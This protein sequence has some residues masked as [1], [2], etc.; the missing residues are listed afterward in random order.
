MEVEF[1]VRTMQCNLR[2]AG[3]HLLLQST[4][5]VIVALHY[6]NRSVKR[7]RNLRQSSLPRHEWCYQVSAVQQYVTSL[8]VNIS[9]RLLQIPDI[10]MAIRQERTLNRIKSSPLRHLTYF[11][12]QI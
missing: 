9:K 12:T 6:V 11:S 10:V 7:L 8:R 1:G 5:T 2:E 4:I 3:C